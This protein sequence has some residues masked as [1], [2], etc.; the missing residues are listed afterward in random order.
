MCVCVSVLLEQTEA[1]PTTALLLLTECVFFFSS[2]YAS[3]SLDTILMV[4]P[5]SML[6]A[7]TVGL[8]LLHK[9]YVSVCVRVCCPKRQNFPLI[10]RQVSIKQRQWKMQFVA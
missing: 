8:A 1:A 5:T 7:H 9:L 10:L 4:W 2:S 6:A 3:R